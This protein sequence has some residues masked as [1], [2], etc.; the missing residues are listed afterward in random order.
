MSGV[1]PVGPDLLPP[2]P[3]IRRPVISRTGRGEH[4]GGARDVFVGLL[5]GVLA[6]SNLV[7]A[8][9]IENL[10]WLDLTSA[11][12][13]LILCV[14]AVELFRPGIVRRHLPL[15]ASL[16]FAVALGYY[17][18]GLNPGATEKRWEIVPGVLVTVLAGYL[19]MTN[20]TRVK[21]FAATVVVQACMVAAAIVVIPDP[22]LAAVSGRTS[23]IG[24]NPIAS[25]RILACGALILI[26]LGSQ[27]ADTIRG[28]LGILLAVPLVTAAV[29]TG[30]RGPLMALL[31]AVALVVIRRRAGSWLARVSLIIIGSSLCGL[32][33]NSLTASN[34]RLADLNDPVRQGLLTE[35][36]KIALQHPFGLGWGNLYNYLPAWANLPMQGYNQY[37]HNILVEFMVEGGWLS[38]L[39]F[40]VFGAGVLK[41]GWLRADD[42]SARLLLALAAY[43]MVSAMLSSDLVGSR[44]LW[45]VAGASLATLQR[46]V[47]GGLSEGELLREP[48]PAASRPVPP[49][50][51]PSTSRQHRTGPRPH[52]APTSS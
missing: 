48:A 4:R 51:E 18:V 43:A 31:L 23:P 26:C 25:G 35:S 19:L 45:V 46:P 52:P 37:P 10:P 14:I 49:R 50:A 9:W 39:L 21:V 42:P 47:T 13:V 16:L 7:Q 36:T 17:K 5:L 11:S 30:S 12:F 8:M 27:H 34:S 2:G 6:V 33:I 41:V 20:A 22:G 44:L 1:R 15:L 38:A 28:R 40:V 29:A 32:L 24:L 3:L